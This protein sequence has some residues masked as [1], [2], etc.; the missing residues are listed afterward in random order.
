[1]L[2]I[3]HAFIVVA[4]VADAYLITEFDVALKHA[5]DNIRLHENKIKIGF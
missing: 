1:M 3:T 2:K 4:F 5:I